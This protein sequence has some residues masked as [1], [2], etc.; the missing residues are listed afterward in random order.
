M[1]KNIQIDK[2]ATTLTVR[3]DLTERPT[4]SKEGRLILATTGG[5]MIKLAGGLQLSVLCLQDKK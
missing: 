2:G 3:I 1:M 4:P 5:R